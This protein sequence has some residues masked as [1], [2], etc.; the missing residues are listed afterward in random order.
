VRS[1]KAE[2]CPEPRSTK[3]SGTDCMLY[4]R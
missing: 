2:L 3:L 4:D 1:R